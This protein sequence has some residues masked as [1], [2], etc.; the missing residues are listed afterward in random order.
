MVILRY[1]WSI[2]E[3]EPV[4]IESLIFFLIH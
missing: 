3:K 1:I 4:H 2:D